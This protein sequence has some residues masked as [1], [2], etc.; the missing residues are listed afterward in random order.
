MNKNKVIFLV[1]W[2]ILLVFFISIFSI[3]SSKSAKKTNSWKWN[4]SIWI[5]WDDKAKFNEVL[6]DFKEKFPK[7][8]NTS[9]NIVSFSSYEDYYNSLVWAFLIW[10]APDIFSLN[11]NDS[12]FFDLQVLWID[13]NVISPDDFRKNYD[14][15]F[16]ND[17]IRKTKV[18]DKDVEFLAWIPL[19]YETLW[20]FYNFREIKGKK[21]TTWSYVNDVIRQ[22]SED[23]ETWI[24]IWNWTTVHMVE[25]IITQFLLLDW[26]EKLSDANWDKLKASISN[27]I[28]FGD[29]N[30]ENKYNSFYKDIVW[31]NKNNL[32]LFSEWKVRMVLWYPRMLEEIDKNWFDKSFLRAESFPTYK[33]D[34][35]KI[36]VNYNYLVINK[37]T[38]FQ[39]LALDIMKYF[40]SAEWQKKYLEKF[41]YYMPS[42]LSLINDRLEEN[43]KDWYNLKYKNFYNPKLELTSFN[44]W[45]RTIY[46]KEVPLILDSWVNS[47]DLFEILRKRLLCISNKMITQTWLENPCK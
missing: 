42:M 26:I 25:D 40:A 27:Y 5:I 43:L 33:E 14:T 15:V 38:Q 23:W 6:N 7:Y 20:L 41:A 3:L 2:V 44:K 10:K 13:P 37:N 19:W 4:F 28:R 18:D 1:I 32:N 9:F 21:L 29:E 47:V 12:S 16:S 22:L 8:K 45:I 31:T 11:N 39:E 36:L 46:D 30:M 34:E 17:L 35:W 24:W